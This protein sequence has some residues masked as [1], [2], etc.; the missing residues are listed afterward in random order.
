M[1]IISFIIYLLLLYIDIFIYYYFTILFVLFIKRNNKYR[2][3]F[4]INMNI[5]FE[6]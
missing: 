3:K 1:F 6:Y 5:S 2:K 4:Y